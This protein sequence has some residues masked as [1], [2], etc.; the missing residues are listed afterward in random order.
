[1]NSTAAAPLSAT[2]HAT[3]VAIGRAG[4]LLLG[5]SGSGKSDLALRLIDQPARPTTELARLV[6]DDQTSLIVKADRLLASAPPVLLG[7]LEV[8][9]LGI[10]K[11]MGGQVT[12]HV[13][14]VLAVE[15]VAPDRV[16][17]MPEASRYEIL[18]VSLPLL[19]LAPFE[20]SAPAK[21]RLALK[22]LTAG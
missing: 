3:A 14:L 12:Q 10:V 8:R 22:S 5:R 9:G 1:M 17:R 11:L 19:H 13:P 15:L 4:V 7:R 16:E 21:L 20:A 2:V 6:A 18:G